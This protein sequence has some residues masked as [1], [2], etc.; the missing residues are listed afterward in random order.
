MTF[1]LTE[2]LCNAIISAMENQDAVF[3]VDAKNTQLVERINGVEPDDELFYSLPEWKPA[4]GFSMRE[5][6]VNQ[7]HAPLAHDELQ[8]VLHSGRGVFKNFR[9]VIKEFPEVEKRWHIYK[10]KFMLERINEWYDS[11]RE[12]WGLEKLDLV[13]E[14]DDGLVY[15]DFSFQEYNPSVHKKTILLNISNVENDEKNLP[16]EV[17]NAILGMWRTQFENDN[18]TN[19]IGFICNSLSDD[20][21]GCITAS[22][23]LQNQD[24]IM[25]ITSLFVPETFCGLGIA[26]EL[27]SLCVKKLKSLSKKWVII[28]NYLAP[29]ILQPL[30]LRTGFNK[31][32]SG[33]LL[34]L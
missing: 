15:D 5:S 30:L 26:T 13:S 2:P 14:S 21:A 31:I 3:I 1:N 4:D 19:Q 9:N 33:Y 32:S 6:F 16:S 22:S 23:C 18:S 20:F 34:L 17:N 28:P 24:K 7:L 25:V 11:L 12:I 27:I 8:N 10:N 29:E